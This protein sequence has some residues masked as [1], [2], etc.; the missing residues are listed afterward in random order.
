MSHVLVAENIHK[1]YYLGRSAL[2]VLRGVNF[3][4]DGGEFVSIT[5]ASGSGKS[6][7][8]HVV[9]GLDVM[10]ALVQGDQIRSIRVQ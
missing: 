7:L 3:R 2:P 4:V 6:T 8:L 10:D 1:T 9:S 5:G